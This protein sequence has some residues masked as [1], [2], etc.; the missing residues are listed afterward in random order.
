MR[1]I[2]LNAPTTL[3]EVKNLKQNYQGS[4]E[5]NCFDKKK[6]KKTTAARFATCNINA[7]SRLNR[8]YSKKPVLEPKASMK[9]IVMLYVKI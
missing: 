3:S 2:F 6:Q 5:E 1:L 9:V 7:A 8:L 4:N